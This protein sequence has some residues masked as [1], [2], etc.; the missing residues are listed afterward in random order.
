MAIRAFLI[1]LAFNPIAAGAIAVAGGSILGVQA[2]NNHQNP[3]SN[4]SGNGGGIDYDKMASAFS[5]VQVVNK[6]D[7]YATSKTTAYNGTQQ[8]NNKLNTSF[9]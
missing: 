7:S 5:R 9:P 4:S 2:Y 1:S 6:V 3:S 8:S